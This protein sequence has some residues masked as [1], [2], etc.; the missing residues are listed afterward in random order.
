MQA[1][2]AAALTA[3]QKLKRSYPESRGQRA[4]GTAKSRR[5]TA[6]PGRGPSAA[7]AAAAAAEAADIAAAIARS[8]LSGAAAW[9]PPA[10]NHIASGQP[11]LQPFPGG[12][13]PDSPPVLQVP[14]PSIAAP[15]P[16]RQT[17]PP[18]HAVKRPAAGGT[19]SESPD[20]LH[21]AQRPRNDEGTVGGGGLGGGVGTS[22]S[23][24]LSPSPPHLRECLSEFCKR[25]EYAQ[26]LELCPAT[27]SCQPSP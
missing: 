23:P 4:A 9:A 10:S 26:M 8:G 6:A 27:L 17:P 21:R 18:T 11:S 25:A 7:P 24:S 1:A 3:V 2:V 5:R 15:A 22:P 13:A 20:K 16:S 19:G 12:S 14:G